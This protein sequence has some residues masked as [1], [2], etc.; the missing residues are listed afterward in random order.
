MFMRY[1][2]FFLYMIQAL[3]YGFYVSLP[4]TYTQVPDYQTLSI[5]ALAGLPYSFKFLMGNQPET[6]LPSLNA[7]TSEG[8]ASARPGSSSA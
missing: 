6:Q 3:F 1:M 8:T 5:F 7:S 4:L 2:I